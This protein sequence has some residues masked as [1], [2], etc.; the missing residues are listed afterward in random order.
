MNL[1]EY[2]VQSLTPGLCSHLHQAEQ[3]P[4]EDPLTEATQ[5]SALTALAPIHSYAMGPSSGASPCP[6]LG[7]GL[8]HLLNTS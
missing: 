4:Q 8:A 2:H 7:A 3:S 5:A 1:T 6:I